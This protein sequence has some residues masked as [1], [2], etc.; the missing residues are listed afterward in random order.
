M[1]EHGNRIM[2]EVGLSLEMQA[3]VMGCRLQDGWYEGFMK[4]YCIERGIV[5][6]NIGLGFG[7][8][9]CAAMGKRRMA[10]LLLSNRVVVHRDQLEVFGEGK[11]GSFWGC[12]PVM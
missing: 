6:E 2:T 10:L 8:Y 5:E 4:E 3:D 11:G 1:D 7:D 12:E 9:V